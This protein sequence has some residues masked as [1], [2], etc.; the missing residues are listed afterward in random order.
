MELWNNN[1]EFRK[2]YVKH[3]MISTLRR[4]K[5][6]DGRSLGPDEEPPLLRNLIEKRTDAARLSSTER[7]TSL[8]A[9]ASEM[10]EEKLIVPVSL[11]ESVVKVEAGQKN[12]APRS[13]KTA[14]LT[15]TE[16][17]SVTVPSR[18]EVVEE[19]EKESKQTKEEEEKAKKAEELARKEEELRKEEAAAKLREQR[20]LEEKAK[21]EAAEERKRRNAEKA[22]ARAELR[23]KKE[24]ELKEKVSQSIPNPQIPEMFL[25]DNFPWHFM[26][27]VPFSR[28]NENL[29]H[30]FLWF[31]FFIFLCH[32]IS[33]C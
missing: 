12:L 8:V 9:S 18:V 24:A 21:A 10:K 17:V 7:V 11:E 31:Q 27:T 32:N 13:K 4:L 19:T 6:L 5:T 33:L 30:H 29:E 16:T 26:S 25:C 28:E 20:R 23:A 2:D 14:K 1:D 22:Q 15:S 3:N